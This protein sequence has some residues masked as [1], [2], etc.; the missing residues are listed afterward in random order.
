MLNKWIEEEGVRLRFDDYVVDEKGRIHAYIFANDTF[1][2]E[3]LV[4][5][6][7]AFVKL[8]TGERKFAEQLLAAQ[9][10]AQ[11]SSVGIWRSISPSGDGTIVGD[12]DRGTF[13][14]PDCGKLAEPREG[15]IEL[16]GTV[17][18]FDK[19]LAPCGKCKP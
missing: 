15:R 10:E 8:R 6:G 5:D 13:H 18:A 14:R 19:G 2:N 16:T 9:R 7:L 4:R 1:I 3:R 11:I 17:A 12:P